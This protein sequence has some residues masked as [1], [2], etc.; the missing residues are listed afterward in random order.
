MATAEFKVSKRG[1]E[2]VKVTKDLPDNL[3]DP[4]WKDIV[5]KPEEDIHELALQ[6]L[7]VKCQAGARARLEAGE[8]AVQAYVDA[9]QYGARTGGFSAPSIAAAD[10][11]AQGFSEEQMAYLRAA[12]MKIESGEEAEATAA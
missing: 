9:Y 8:A 2:S 3:D 5:L 1:G 10:A 11:Q 12:G 7:I 6:A 4:R